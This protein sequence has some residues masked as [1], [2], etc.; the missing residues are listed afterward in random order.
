MI[1]R[2]T[3]KAFVIAAAVV[4]VWESIV[5]LGLVSQIILAAPSDIVMAAA[6]DG[7]VFL[8][9]FATTMIEIGAAILIAWTLGI[10]LGVVVGSSQA[11]SAATT[12]VL[13]SIFAIPLIILYPLLMAWLGIGPL[14]KVVFAVLSGFFPIALNTIDG[15]RAIERR[16]LVFARSIGATR[17][18]TYAR[19][20]FPLAL[21]AMVSGLRVGTG[22]VVI[23]VIVTE[24]LASLGGIGFLISY[25]R[26]LF[27]TGH[28]YF[29]MALALVMAAAVNIGLTWLDRRIGL[30][31][32]REQAEG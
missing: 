12:P 10:V 5:R 7:D 27:N 28:V 31:R 14:S 30:W 2:R 6:N 19:I 26:S 25:H 9:A 21:P 29:G 16:Y 32:M 20:V 3:I 11:L 17:L 15:V 18:Q 4:A 1:R 23:G 22:L 8:R 13:S 24:M